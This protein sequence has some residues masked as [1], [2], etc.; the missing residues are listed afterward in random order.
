MS[1]LSEE[2]CGQERQGRAQ[3]RD[4]PG[5]QQEE[6]REKEGR[7]RLRNERRVGRGS[8]RRTSQEIDG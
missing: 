3:T 6:R 4:R 7:S 1:E 2:K 5:A 8:P